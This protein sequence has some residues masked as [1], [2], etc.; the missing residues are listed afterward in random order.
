MNMPLPS[1]LVIRKARV[2]RLWRATPELFTLDLELAPE[3][4]FAFVAGQWVYLHSLNEAGESIA[5]AAFSIASAPSEV[6]VSLGFGIKIYGRLTSTFADMKV[7]DV[8]GVQG[9]FGV[10][11]LP[12][13]CAPLVLLAGGIGVTPMRSLIR[14]ALDQGWPEPIALLWTTKTEEDLIYHQEFLRWQA[15]SNGRFRYYPSLTKELRST[16]EGRRGRISEA[17]LDDLEVDWERAH[18]YVCGPDHYMMEAKTLLAK[19]GIQGK[20][21]YHEEKF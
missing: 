17:Q 15:E 1:V 13:E 9:P 19:R 3:D 20:P 2:T 5:R 8:L 14:G 16:W 12:P 4:Q 11:V 7:G 18:A 21:R 6:E 10:F